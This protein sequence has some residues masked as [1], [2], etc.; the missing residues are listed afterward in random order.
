MAE[1]TSPSA[2][3]DLDKSSC[4][5]S[6]L[7]FTEDGEGGEIDCAEIR[8]TKE[9]IFRLSRASASRKNFAAN[10]VRRVFTLEERTS[11]GCWGNKN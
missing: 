4:E 1:S 11:R 6:L 7:T 10:L 2:G 5:R 9:E 3:L 8:V